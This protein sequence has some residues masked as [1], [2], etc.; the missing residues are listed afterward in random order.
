[1]YS[2]LGARRRWP[3]RCAAD[4]ESKAWTLEMGSGLRRC[5]ARPHA[6]ALARDVPLVGERR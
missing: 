1:M 4:D 3:W 6:L 5:R 2:A